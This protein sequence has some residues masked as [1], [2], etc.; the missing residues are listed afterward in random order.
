MS[1]TLSKELKTDHKF[2]YKTQSIKLSEKLAGE[3][4]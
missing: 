1:H 2:K 4:L 3:K